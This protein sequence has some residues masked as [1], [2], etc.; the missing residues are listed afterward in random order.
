[1]KSIYI[2]LLLTFTSHVAFSQSDTLPAYLQVPIVPPFKI[3]LTDG[4]WFSKSDLDKKPSLILYF[5]PDC[6]HCQLET[7]EIISRA[8]SLTK[9]QIL[10]LN[11]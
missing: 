6:G 1:M 10:E 5:S 7:E 3:Q 11:R 8:K 9:L 2:L 4:S